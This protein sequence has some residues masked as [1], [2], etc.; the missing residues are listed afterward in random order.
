MHHQMN[1]N[2]W[3]NIL[4]GLLLLAVCI[5]AISSKFFIKDVIE[6]LKIKQ[7]YLLL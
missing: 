5:Y 4:S 3:L 2:H 6:N 7:T 1:H